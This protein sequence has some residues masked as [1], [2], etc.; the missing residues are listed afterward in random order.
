MT[1]PDYYDKFKC[2]A[3]KCVHNC[4]RG[5]WEIEI[6][7]E[8]LDR[9]SKLPGEFGD[10]VRA[11]ISPENIFIHK[12][13]EC[14]LLSPE[15]KCE[16]V[17]NGAELCVICDEYPRFTEFFGD[18][19]ER[20]ISLSCE[21]SA[22]IILHKKDK[23]EIIFDTAADCDEPIFVLLKKAR[24]DIF[25]ILQDRDADIFKRMRLALDYGRHLQDRINENNFKSFEYTPS[26]TFSNH[27]SL[28]EIIPVF[29]ELSILNKEW[30]A[31]LEKL[32][33]D[34]QSRLRHT[35]DPII[36]EQLA[37]YFVYRYLLKAAFDCDAF[38]KLKF[39]FLSVMMIAALANSFGNIEEC[40]RLYSVEIEHSEEN[41]DIIYDE[42]LF[43][44]AFY[45]NNFINIIS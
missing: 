18:Y 8:A 15:G 30:A 3:D 13:G 37:V 24:D 29:K 31:M 20:G 26:D 2:I 34:E 44:D 43:N 9:F 10:K 25:A 41:I 22:D 11:S 32:E 5:G 27:R 4:C 19:A 36:G 16:M 28:S 17:L 42:F 6:D 45:H 7:D 40:A 14:P 38:A 39:S 12:H 21:A 33:A 35:L 23:S 1:H